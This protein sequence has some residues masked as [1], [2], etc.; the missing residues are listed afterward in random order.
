MKS[1][2]S[3]AKKL[4]ND[5]RGVFGLSSVQQFF[6]II[7]GIALLAYVI[8][9]VMGTLQSS[10]VL[11]DASLSATVINESGSALASGYTLSNSS[12]V[13]FQSP[14]IVH[15]ING[16]SGATI[17]NLT[18]S[19]SGVVT[20]S[21]TD[22]YAN[23]NITYSYNYD[24]DARANSERI[25]A[26]TSGGVTSFFSSVNPVYAILAILV[27]ILVLLVLV[28]VVTGGAGVGGSRRSE[29]QL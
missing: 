6:A 1:L 14:T 23:A 19:G 3:K 27:I 2:I 28:R 11:P 13:G 15:A 22:S 10:T 25:L 24:T 12:R 4:K 5:K 26:N 21:S 20:N 29:P 16:S 18:V 9:V 17:V 7:L 8:V